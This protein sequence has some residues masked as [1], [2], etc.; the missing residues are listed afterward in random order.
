MKAVFIAATGQNV[1]KT[2]LCLG[3]IAALRKL[4]PSVGFIKPVG[5]QHFKLENGINVDKDVYL[6]R[7]YF[8]LDSPGKR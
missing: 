6:F 7:E 8:H 1:G 4:Y 3:L 5:Q 2:T